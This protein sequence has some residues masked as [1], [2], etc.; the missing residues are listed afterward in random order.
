MTGEYQIPGWPLLLLA[1][2]PLVILLSAGVWLLLAGGPVE[3]EG[4]K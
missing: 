4:D 1:A 2:I 3:E